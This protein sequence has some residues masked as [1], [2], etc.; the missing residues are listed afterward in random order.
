[1]NTHIRHTLLSLLILV[2]AL[3]AS[4]GISSVSSKEV[5][6]P[7]SPPVASAWEITVAPYG[8]L[9]GI[10]GTMGVGGFSADVDVPFSKILD[11]LD[12]VG[13]VQL[14]IKHD[15][16]MLLLDGMYLRLSAGSSDT[17]GRL[18]SSVGVEVEQ[19]LAEA[20]LAYRL[21]EGKRG[22]LDVFVGARYLYLG[23]ELSLNLDN[24]GV[25]DISTDLSQAV[26]GRLTSAVQA[27][28][29]DKA[30]ELGTKGDAAI[31][32]IAIKI[33]KDQ[34]TDLIGKYPR[35]PELLHAINNGSGPVNAAIK[36]LIAAK[37][38]QAQG[39]ALDDATALV[40]AQVA[41]AKAKA[42]EQLKRAVSR[43][44]KQLAKKIESTIKNSIPDHVAAS[45]SWVDPIVGARARYNFSDR[46]YAIARADVGGFGVGSDIT[47]QAYG[48]I[49]YQLT[50]H[51]TLELGYRHLYVDYAD[52][53]FSYDISTSG[54]QMAIGYRF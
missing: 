28:I 52:G 54:V 18:F 34:A 2:P 25:S 7:P 51:T 39:E 49:G 15:R 50:A 13:A 29:S 11:H 4:A 27:A 9:A 46:F 5:I 10:S 17:P 23:N 3:P 8:W 43:A 14:E 31:Q 40:S 1:M 19:V 21:L 30:P 36:D 22:F 37:V 47:W 33:L 24:Q 26:V 6:A 48:A 45:K 53:N 38:E 44:E 32:I 41:A 20:D 35:L 16:W 12:M 42:K